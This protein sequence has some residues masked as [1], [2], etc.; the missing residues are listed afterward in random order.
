MTNPKVLELL[1]RAHVAQ[2]VGPQS[3]NTVKSREYL[4]KAI[5]ALNDIETAPT[6]DIIELNRA[7]QVLETLGIPR[8]RARNI[9]NGIDVLATR[10]SREV[11]AQRQE[12]ARLHALLIEIRTLEVGPAIQAKIDA[13]VLPKATEAG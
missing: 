6:S 11:E 1:Q 12:I 13:V 7:Y 2:C 10:Y 5:S 4:A 8:S 3:E 9:P